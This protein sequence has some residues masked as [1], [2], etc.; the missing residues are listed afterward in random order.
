MVLVGGVKIF[1]V[2]VVA[3]AA[4]VARLMIFGGRFASIQTSSF[5]ST[6]HV[7]SS[8]VV[9][10]KEFEFGKDAVVLFLFLFFSVDGSAPE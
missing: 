3:A 9:L 6:V 1:V 2:V 10:L 5:T 4:A 7:I 8:L